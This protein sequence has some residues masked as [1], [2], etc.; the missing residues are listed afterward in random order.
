MPFDGLRAL[1]H[2]TMLTALRPSKGMVE[3]R[4]EPVFVPVGLRRGRRQK[5][6]ARGIPPRCGGLTWRAGGL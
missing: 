3:G 4:I 6:T 5:A 2:S 1:S